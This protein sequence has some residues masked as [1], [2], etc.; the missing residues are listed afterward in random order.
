MNGVITYRG[1]TY[2]LD[3]LSSHER[4]FCEQDMVH[5]CT[6]K[7]LAYWSKRFSFGG[8]VMDI[9]KYFDIPLS[10]KTPKK[11]WYSCGATLNPAWDFWVNHF[12]T[13]EK[14]KKEF[15]EDKEWLDYCVYIATKTNSLEAFNNV[16]E[17][18]EIVFDELRKFRND[19]D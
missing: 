16:K 2:Y 9:K 18:A 8:D 17:N 11:H 14:Y 6:S 5:S 19:L 13:F 1:V 15:G 7:I 3:K 12:P 10:T 4:I